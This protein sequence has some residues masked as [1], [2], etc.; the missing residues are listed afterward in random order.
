MAGLEDLR[1]F[2]ANVGEGLNRCVNN[3]EFY[4][5]M[6]NKAVEDQAFANLEYAIGQN[7]LKLA[8][9]VAHALKGVLANLGLTPICEP[10]SEMVELLRNGTETDYSGYL[11][12]IAEK[13]AELQRILQ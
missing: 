8:F 6:L 1:A 2:G 10:V 11:A 12:K 4:L 13:K 9:E 5:K 3:E 7:D